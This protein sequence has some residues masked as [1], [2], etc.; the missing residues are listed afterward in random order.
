MKTVLVIDDEFAALYAEFIKR[1]GFNTLIAE[2]GR[3]GIQ[4]AHE[5]RPDLIICDIMMGE[6]D[7]YGVLEA[8]RNDQL[9]A[10]TPFI[11]VTAKLQ[12]DYVRKG[13]ILGADD[14]ITKPITQHELIE[15]IDALFAKRER[16]LQ[17]VNANSVSNLKQHIFLS[18]S[19]KDD[20]IM[21][22]VR[23]ALKAKHLLVWV[24]EEGL[25]PGTRS[26]KKVIQ[27]AIDDTGCVVVILSP[28][29]KESEWVEAELDYA[30]SQGK[31]IFPILA[32]GNK[33]NAVPFGYTLAQWIDIV[34]KDYESE[35]DKLVKSIRKHLNLT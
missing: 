12:R 6:P 24:D 34:E 33:Q 27:R 28:D 29:A 4:L 16:L 14:Y 26:W 18:Y 1:G 31:T 35:M 20:E 13:M 10:A 25:N 30:E 32:R 11:F 7:G 9:L 22:R 8:I 21:R 23:E 15:A 19:R 17:T 3:V 2:N 5:Y